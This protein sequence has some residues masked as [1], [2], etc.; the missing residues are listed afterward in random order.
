MCRQIRR[1]V[2][3]DESDSAVLCVQ[4]LLPC[5]VS[6][7]STAT[8]KALTSYL[9]AFGTRDQNGRMVLLSVRKLDLSFVSVNQPLVDLLAACCPNVRVLRATHVFNTEPPQSV[10]L[11]P[12]LDLPQVEELDISETLYRRNLNQLLIILAIPPRLRVIRSAGAHVLRPGIGHW[13]K[14][15]NTAHIE[16]WEQFDTPLQALESLE[17]PLFQPVNGWFSEL[18]GDPTRLL[19]LL[20]RCPNL[21]Y[22]DASGWTHSKLVAWGGWHQARTDCASLLSDLPGVLVSTLVTHCTRLRSLRLRRA[23]CS[24]VH[25]ARLLAELPHLEVLETD[26]GVVERSSVAASS[27]TPCP[28]SQYTISAVELAQRYCKWRHAFAQ[29]PDINCSNVSDEHQTYN[30]SSLPSTLPAYVAEVCS[31]IPRTPFSWILRNAANYQLTEDDAPRGRSTLG[32]HF[33]ESDSNGFAQMI[34]DVQQAPSSI[35]HPNILETFSF[36]LLFSGRVLCSFGA[37]PRRNV[38]CHV[39]GVYPAYTSLLA[40]FI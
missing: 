25:I 8:L 5:Y 6:P 23:S 20:H 27:S 30:S 37:S 38:P 18:E 32:T 24:T 3:S 14:Q 17:V 33:A 40:S 34:L 16:P 15:A 9:S 1:L 26:S 10:I 22:L 39:G 28:R 13:V 31:R 35:F 29:R 36:S 4:R 12:L 11:Q 21:T 7:N 19:K 2:L